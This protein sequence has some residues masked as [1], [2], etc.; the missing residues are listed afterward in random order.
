[1]SLKT[2]CSVSMAT[3]AKNKCCEERNKI[4]VKIPYC[5]RNERL[6][7]TFI[8]KLNKFAG[9]NHIFIDHPLAKLFNLKDKN[10]HRTH[11]VYKGECCCGDSYIAE[12][13]RNV[14]VRIREHSNAC[15]DSEPAGH[16]RDG[17]AYTLHGAILS[18]TQNF[19][20]SNDATMETYSK[21]TTSLLH[22]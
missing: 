7:K 19:L 4:I 21:Q 13:M 17:L 3:S 16:L 14:K 11:V 15:N 1:M 5:S 20:R 10:T 9:F 12:T 2:Q 8:S 6:S 18:Q 22:S